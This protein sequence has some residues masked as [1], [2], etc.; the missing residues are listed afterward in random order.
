MSDKQD[1]MPKLLN[2]GSGDD[3]RDGWLNIDIDSSINPD[4]VVDLDEYPWPFPSDHFLQVEA[5]HVFE[6]V[7]DPLVAFREVTRILQDGGEFI[8]TY[9][10]GHTRFEDPTHKQFWN[11]HTASMLAGERKHAHEVDV[12]LELVDRDLPWGISKKEPLIYLYAYY[13]L[14]FRG[15]GPW[16]DGIPGLYGEVTATYKCR[17]E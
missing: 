6:H 4:M 14:W 13:R 9:P 5:R 12:S 15:I 2:L 11:W 10:I 16:I 1:N 8:F 7:S 17:E 3:Y